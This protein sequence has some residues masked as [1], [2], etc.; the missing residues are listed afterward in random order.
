MSSFTKASNKTR[1]SEKKSRKRNQIKRGLIVF[2]W[3]ILFSIISL[4]CVSCVSGNDFSLLSELKSSDEYLGESNNIK[5]YGKN[6]DKLGNYKEI[7][8]EYKEKELTL[9][10]IKIY[11]ELNMKREDSR[12]MNLLEYKD[13]DIIAIAY[14]EKV[15]DDDIEENII[16]I[17]QES[18][19]LIEPEDINLFVNKKLSKDKLRVEDK[20]YNL[21]SAKADK[22]DPDIFDRK[23]VISS[24]KKTRGIEVFALKKDQDNYT[25]IYARITGT[26]KVIPLADWSQFVYINGPGIDILDLNMDGKD[27]AII[28]FSEKTADDEITWQPCF[29]DIDKAK[30]VSFKDL[31]LE[32]IINVTSQYD[33]DL[34]EIEG[35]PYRF[36]R[37]HYLRKEAIIEE[38]LDMGMLER[39]RCSEDEGICLSLLNDP[40]SQISAK[41]SP[42]V[43]VLE[44]DGKTKLYEA[45]SMPL[46]SEISGYNLSIE[47]QRMDLN[48]DKRDEIVIVFYTGSGT[49]ISA[50]DLHILNGETLEEMYYLKNYDIEMLLSQYVSSHIYIDG[51]EVKFDIW[52]ND[53]LADKYIYSEEYSDDISY[54]DQLR[55]GMITNYTLNMDS[56]KIE[57]EVSASASITSFVGYFTFDL[58]ISNGQ[59]VF[60]K[61][62]FTQN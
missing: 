14:G 43:F 3:L 35:K 12:R 30:E 45:W 26:D 15:S 44:T 18:F 56:N 17:N 7:R 50:S 21:Y 19:S 5:V 33:S 34:Q 52:L 55:L 57:V 28:Y 49:E 54:F 25:D 27:E 9:D 42:S 41:L 58:R 32:N 23:T 48:G 59:L 22:L 10:N 16:F 13:I 29:I 24:N 51:K 8:L 37:Y 4:L 62:E 11:S 53:A 61:I 20:T 39:L 1:V 31:N 40:I 60:Q 47:I 36:N 2:K 46:Y 38:N 6:Q